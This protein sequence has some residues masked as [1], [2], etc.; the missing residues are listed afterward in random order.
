MAALI[1]EER[2]RAAIHISSVWSRRSG[3]DRGRTTILATLN[4]AVHIGLHQ[5]LKGGALTGDKSVDVELEPVLRP[6][7]ANDTKRLRQ[8]VVNLNVRPIRM[9]LTPRRLQRNRRRKLDRDERG[10][11]R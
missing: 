1:A 11:K 2:I 8:P 4:S 3:C 6:G 10:I 7:A 5:P 9:M